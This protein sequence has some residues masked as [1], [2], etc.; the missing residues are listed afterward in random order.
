MKIEFVKS[1]SGIFKM[2]YSAGE[3]ADIDEKTAKNL[4]KDGFA[5]ALDEEKPTRKSTKK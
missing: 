2:A 1:P 4:I 5:I 3:Q